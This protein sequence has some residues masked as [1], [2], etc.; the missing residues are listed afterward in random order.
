M[1]REEVISFLLDMQK[2]AEP[3]TGYTP[4][5]VR[6]VCEAAIALLEQGERTCQVGWEDNNPYM[7]NAND[8][9]E[10]YCMSCETYFRDYDDYDYCPGCGARIKKEE[11]HE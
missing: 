10:A 3:Y 4:I 2:H 8:C 5:V 9:W 6:S 11:G 1:T 7:D